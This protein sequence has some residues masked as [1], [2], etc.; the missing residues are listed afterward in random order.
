[1][2]F[3]VTTI[4]IIEVSNFVQIVDLQKRLRNVFWQY[5]LA[6]KSL[7]YV[8]VYTNPESAI[9]FTICLI[10]FFTCLAYNTSDMVRE[11]ALNGIFSMFPLAGIIK[12]MVYLKICQWMSK[13]VF[14]R[15]EY[16]LFVLISRFGCFGVTY[17]S[18][19][20]EPPPCPWDSCS[21]PVMIT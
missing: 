2:L 6:R 3:L 15:T 16:L 9:D 11:M 21:C 1:M 12:L 17:V 19:S 13:R 4:W 20:M 14:Y 7:W 18:R 5:R 8:N 10:T